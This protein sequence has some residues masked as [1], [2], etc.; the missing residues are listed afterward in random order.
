MRLNALKKI[1]RRR[2]GV[3]AA[4]PAIPSAFSAEIYAAAGL[5]LA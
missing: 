3:S 5:G 2:A 1:R 4:G